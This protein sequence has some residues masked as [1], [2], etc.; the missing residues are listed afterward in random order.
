MIPDL[1]FIDV[2]AA[3]THTFLNEHAAHLLKLTES[4][5]FHRGELMRRNRVL[6]RTVAEVLR[7]Y[8]DSALG[9][10]VAGLCFASH[11]AD[12]RC[13]AV[14][15]DRLRFDD[16]QHYLVTIELDVIEEA[17]KTLG[18]DLYP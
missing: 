18:V 4:G 7:D 5:L 11:L 14:W 10:A 3:S 1:P 15:L 8:A 9:G 2:D 13:Y 12:E 17:A 6:T 16:P